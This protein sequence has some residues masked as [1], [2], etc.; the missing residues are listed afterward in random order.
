MHLEK[1]E[2][3]KM[4]LSFHLLKKKNTQGN[5]LREKYKKWGKNPPKFS[6]QFTASLLKCIFQ[7]LSPLTAFEKM[8]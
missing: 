3:I 5:T 1:H 2:H 4:S 6:Q 7:T 8:M